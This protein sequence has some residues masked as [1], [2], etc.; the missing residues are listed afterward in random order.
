M[1]SNDLIEKGA[2]SI[3][4]FCRKNINIKKDLPIRSSEMGLLIYIVKENQTITPVM[5]STFL[6]VSK[7]MVANMVASLVRKGYITKKHSKKDKRSFYIVATK[8][9]EEFVANSYDEYAKVMQTLIS[10]MG[11]SKYEELI[12]M[13]DLAN[14]YIEEMEK[15]NE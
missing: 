9:S 1:Q 6:K 3:S 14:A 2:Q 15:E 12:K 13:L 7:P 4:L 5:A 10:K 8:K 11:E